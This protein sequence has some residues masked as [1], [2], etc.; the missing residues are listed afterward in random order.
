MT[1]HPLLSMTGVMDVLIAREGR[2]ARKSGSEREK[3]KEN[4]EILEARY[5]AMREDIAKNG[6]REPIKVCSSDGFGGGWYIADGRH[7]WIS[8]REAGMAKIPCMIVSE[9]DARAVIHSAL[10]GKPMSK[11]SIA[12]TAVKLYPEV[13]DGEHGGDRKSSMVSNLKITQASLAKKSGV[14]TYT[15]G[16]AVEVYRMLH[17]TGY[18]ENDNP[19]YVPGSKAK[20]EDSI[21][22]SK[23]WSRWSQERNHLLS[24][25]WQS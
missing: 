7:R 10:L 8:A 18:M 11:G 22:C 25:Q 2:M 24:R 23:H 6:V 19:V 21:Y 1:P 16:Q 5:T 15:M 9:S 4:A 13:C 12:Y 14:T 3:H 17:N 20:F